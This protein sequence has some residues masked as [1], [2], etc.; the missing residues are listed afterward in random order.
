MI[1]ALS[2]R[3]RMPARAPARRRP[4]SAWRITLLVDGD[5][6]RAARPAAVRQAR[7]ADGHHRRRHE[8]ADARGRQ[9]QLLRPERLR[10][11]R[12]PGR[13]PARW[14][15]RAA[16]TLPPRSTG[17]LQ[18]ESVQDAEHRSSKRPTSPAVPNTAAG[19]ATFYSNTRLEI[20][21]SGIDR[22]SARTPAAAYRWGLIKLRQT[23]PA[24]RASPNCDKPVR[25][26]GNAALALRQRLQP[27]QR[28]LRPA[29][30][31]S[32]CRRSSAPNYSTK[33]CTAAARA[34]SSRPRTP[35]AIV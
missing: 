4:W 2:S 25:V 13:S 33:R 1:S 14:A 21:K 26:T 30:S 15:C 27:V 3:R 35:S 29:S 9:R 8:H 10:R 34:S 17:N 11:R 28:R 18:Y 22:R 23:S 5:R 31:A 32:T 20:A 24:W 12:R 19:Y 16:T 7:A 6:L